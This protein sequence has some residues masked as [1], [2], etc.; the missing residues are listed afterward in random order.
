MNGAP[1]QALNSSP[2]AASQGFCKILKK[3]RWSSW[4][5]KTGDHAM[6]AVCSEFGAA[7][8]LLLPA[9]SATLKLELEITARENASSVLAGCSAP[10]TKHR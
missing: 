5:C 4:I 10:V 7:K 3:S 9:T 8:M 1:I 2:R 6:V